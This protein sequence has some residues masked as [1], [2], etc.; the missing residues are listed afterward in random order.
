[1]HQKR[2]FAQRDAVK[3]RINC[4]QR[5]LKYVHIHVSPKAPRALQ[6]QKNVRYFKLI[7]SISYWLGE[8]L[9]V[10]G[11]FLLQLAGRVLRLSIWCV[12]NTNLREKTT[13][14]PIIYV[15]K[16]SIPEVV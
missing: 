15:T 16:V 3:T 5:S 8:A 2:V 1:M 7:K 14:Q 10:H 9:L 12:V 6:I 11:L 13:L 4:A